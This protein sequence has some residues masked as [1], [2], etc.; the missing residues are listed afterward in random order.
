[1]SLYYYKITETK[2][3]E[4]TLMVSSNRQSLQESRRRDIEDLEGELDGVEVT[5]IEKTKHNTVSFNSVSY[6]E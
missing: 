4:T 2:D 1:M 5:E 6:I 3:N